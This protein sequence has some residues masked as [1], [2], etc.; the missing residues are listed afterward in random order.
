[1]NNEIKELLGIIDDHKKNE[2]SIFVQNRKATD[3]EIELFG[4]GFPEYIDFIKCVNGFKFRGCCIFPLHEVLE[5]AHGEKNE[6]M[7]LGYYKYL[8]F[9]LD[10]NTGKYYIVNDASEAIDKESESFDEIIVEIIRIIISHIVHED[11]GAFIVYGDWGKTLHE[12][13][14]TIKKFIL[15]RVHT[16]QSDINAGEPNQQRKVSKFYAAKGVWA[17]NYSKG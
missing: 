6:Y 2:D 4:E 10:K 14:E 3:N 9:D 17:G 11:T 8:T 12:K 5:R 1:M 7:E 16:T 15:G 13:T